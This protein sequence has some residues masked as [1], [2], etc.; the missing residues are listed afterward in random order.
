MSH[1]DV[2]H[3]IRA[4]QLDASF[5]DELKKMSLYKVIVQQ[6][7]K[8]IVVAFNNQALMS[9]PL[10][11]QLHKKLKA[12]F[13]LKITLILEQKY[14]ITDFK[15][16]SLWMSYVLK[17]LKLSNI[18]PFYQ[19]KDNV[20]VGVLSDAQHIE[21]LENNKEKINSKLAECGIDMRFETQLARL[22]TTDKE[23]KYQPT[24]EIVKPKTATNYRRKKQPTVAVAISQLD[25]SLSNVSIEGYVYAIET[26]ALSQEDHMILMFVLS[27]G[28]DA[29]SVKRFLKGK[30]QIEEANGLKEN[31]KVTCIGNVQFDRFKKEIGFVANII[32]VES[33]HVYLKDNAPTKRI[34]FHAHTK[35]SEMDAVSDVQELIQQAVAYQHR[36]LIITD[37]VNVQAFPKA[38]A[39]LQ[40]LKKKKQDLDFKLG[41]GVEMNMVDD[42]P[43]IVSQGTS[44]PLDDIEYVIFDLETTGLS[45]QYD[46]I[47]EFGAIKVKN[48]EIIDEYLTFIKPP[49][50]ISSF[51]TSKTN[52]TNS[53]VA[54]APTIEEELDN[55]LQ[56]IKGSVLVAH[57]AQFDVSFLNQA[58]ENYNKPFISVPIIDTLELAR[59]LLIERK[60]FRLGRVARAFSIAYDEEIAH[61]ADYDVKITNKVFYALL[62]LAKEQQV[63]TL[64]DL[65][66]LNHP[67]SFK[68]M[69]KSHVQVIAKNQQGLVDLFRLVSISH[70][71]TLAFYKKANNKKEEDEFMAEA[72]IK[73]GVLAKH[74]THLLI[75][76]GCLNSEIFEIASN[77]TIQQLEAALSFYDF[78]EIQPLNHYQPLIDRNIIPN[79]DRLIMIIHSII[80]AAKKQNIPVLA[81]G[82]VHYVH[83]KDKIF[84]E[85]MIASQGIGGIRHPLYMYDQQKRLASVAPDQHFMSTETMLQEFSYLDNSVAYEL[86]VEAPNR[87]F[88]QIKPIEIIKKE[89]YTPKIAHAD[90]NLTELVYQH[91][92]HKYGNPLPK[93]IEKRI[94]QELDAIKS[95]GFGVIYY[96]AHLLVK[97]SLDDGYLV[98][99][100]GSVGSSFV[101]HL[102]EITEVNP[103]PP[104]YCCPKCHQVIFVEDEGVGSGFDLENKQCETCHVD[105]IV[106][107]QDIPFETFLGFEGDKVP[108]IDLNFSNQY[109]EYAH[110]Y[111]K[112][113]FGEK[114]VYRAGT[115]GTIAARTAYGYA[116]GYAEEMQLPADIK[117]ARWS[118]YASGVEGVKRTSGQHPGGIIVV[119][120][121]MEIYEFTPVQFPANNPDSAWKTTHFEFADI[122]DNLLKLDILG[123]LDPSA[124]KLLEEVTGIDPRTIQMNDPKV[125]SIFSDISALNVD[126]RYTNEVTGAIGLPEF[127]TTFV[128]EILK[129]A[130]PK[131]FSDLVRIS[132]LSH[133]TDV[134]LNNAKDI[135]LSGKT[136]SDVIGC[137]DDIMVYLIHKGLK[138]KQ[139]FDI[140]ESVRKGKGLTPKWIELMKKHEVDDWY[141]DSCQK[142]KY[143]FP[144]AHA[145]AYVIMAVRVAWYK[146]YYPLAYYISYFSLRA[147]AFDVDI[148]LSDVATVSKKLSDINRRLKDPNEKFQVSNKEKELY[149]TLEVVLE[150]KLRGYTFSPIDLYQ[151]LAT[152]FA[153]DK[154]NDKAILLPYAV[155]DGLGANVAKSVVEAREEAPFLSKEDL[156]N[157][158]QLNYNHIKKLDSLGTLDD[159]QEENQCSL[160]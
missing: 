157:R 90:E 44:Q 77:R 20:I 82:D 97:K 67:E 102:A 108:D 140:M 136:L 86:V 43:T 160:F 75:G 142:I 122:H 159:L 134:W 109:Q 138:P 155:L 46:H 52:I 79:Q 18:V 16:C 151:S 14:P 25:E 15:H 59:V 31:S 89:L 130:Q 66:N 30:Q 150:M 81:T 8:R 29:I 1:F 3:F 135:I 146:V 21:I 58:C 127:G 45:A 158:T 51:I 111:T 36:G 112:E 116:K 92:Y 40:K 145:V 2:E 60:S 19:I 148:M 105:F 65:S 47:I 126:E 114:N 68:N 63:Q 124:M 125:M 110:A 27:D 24:P 48:Q 93:K 28:E 141:I 62:A 49:V 117:D 39:F 156:V 106:D 74:R 103:L 7:S 139:A 104:H 115:I 64:E 10:Y 99:S 38:E 72:R 95:N 42:Q 34:E 120:D 149:N 54:D 26:R 33:T 91:A 129:I 57:N 71:D 35:M 6:Q 132:G 69:M 154:N 50:P 98:G 55:I 37:H 12:V 83:P 121:D 41:Y 137:R 11:S 113:L 147:N 87:L 80:K 17:S 32:N 53:L 94:K 22:Q 4:C 123:H 9:Y 119:P 84:R 100:R 76:A 118:W 101:A 23:V 61:R 96:I 107:G 56:F 131:N 70:M 5:S 143:M 144:K 128:R 78:V 153:L 152:E 13:N 85:I 133:G 88:D 73:K